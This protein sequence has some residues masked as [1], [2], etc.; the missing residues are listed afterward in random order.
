M[1]ISDQSARERPWGQ[2]PSAAHSKKTH[3]RGSFSVGSLDG[4]PWYYF[5][6]FLDIGVGILSSIF[7]S[8]LF[9]TTLSSHFVIASI[10]FSLLMDFDFIFHYAKGGT[11]HT[12]YKHRDLF[13]YPLLYIPSGTLILFFLNRE[14]ATLFAL[15]SLLHFIHDS[16]GVGW[17]IQWFYPFNT[18]HYNFIYRYTSPLKEKLP[19]KLVRVWRHD[20]IDSLAERYGDPDWIKNVYINLHWY[21]V[22]EFTVFLVSLFILYLYI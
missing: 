22:V 14:L 5:N 4:E 16:I 3:I 7:V 8:Y 15:C 12:A 9:N 2:H 6:M 17:G 11:K 10:F 1:K 21:A 20:E 19:I 13:H 18:N